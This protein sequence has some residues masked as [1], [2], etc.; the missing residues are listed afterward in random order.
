MSLFT[1]SQANA[2]TIIMMN[3]I[4]QGSN[5]SWFIK[6]NDADGNS[7]DT[8]LNGLGD[9]PSSSDIK[10]AVINEIVDNMLKVGAQPTEATIVTTEITDKGLGETL[11]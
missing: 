7:Y 5:I 11:S 6:F 10:T 1:T 9:D 4:V 3:K 8:T 2:C